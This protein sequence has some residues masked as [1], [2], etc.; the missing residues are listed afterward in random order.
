MIE[1]KSD[2]IV[3]GDPYRQAITLFKSLQM[4]YFQIEKIKIK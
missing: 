1:W 3:C 4:K 2:C